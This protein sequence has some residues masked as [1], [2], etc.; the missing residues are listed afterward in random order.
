MKAAIISMGS[1]SSEWTAKAM[2]KYFEEV[3][4]INLKEIEVNFSGKNSEVL[5]QG[6]DLGKYDCIY[7]KGSFRYAQLLRSI[8]SLLKGKAYIPIE[9]SAYT[10]VHD[11]LLTQLRLQEFNIPM[12]RTY[13][14]ATT[15]AA[16]TLLERTK[17]PIIMKFPQG[18]QGKGV[19]FADSY[20]S[21]SSMLDALSAL[22]QPFIIQE[23]VETGGE[24]IR[25]MVIGDK[26]VV[27]MKRKA[28]ENEIRSNIHAGGTGE[29]AKIDEYTKKV[30]VDTAKAMGVDI[31][32][33]D[34]LYGVKGPQVIEANLSPGLQGITEA[35]GIDVADLIAKYLYEQSVEFK[36]KGKKKDTA[37][38]MNELDTAKEGKTI[39]RPLD[40]RGVRVLLPEIA[41]KISG[42]KE[43]DD[44]ELKMENKKITIEK[45]EVN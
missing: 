16:K 45:F 12:P 21:A 43:S 34:I 36:N 39:I 38:I 22:K 26:A 1:V 27:S 40:F 37:D 28:A 31:C 2:R 13:L 6:K 32:G 9:E 41:T 17:F 24:D 4:E 3:D 7:A 15:E 14:S 11:K 8:V 35:T 42:I 29:I 19:M 20:A 18:T 44:V 23:F 10:I 25:V 5:Y 33:V 30:A